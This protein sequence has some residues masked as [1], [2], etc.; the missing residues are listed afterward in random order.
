MLVNVA[1]SEFNCS[2]DALPRAVKCL[3]DHKVVQKFCVVHILDE[4]YCVEYEEES[5]L[6][7]DSVHYPIKVASQHLGDKHNHPTSIS[8]TKDL[9]EFED[10]D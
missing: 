9:P 1:L 8:E 2:L 10:Y 3:F 7:P 5:S 6:H 4:E